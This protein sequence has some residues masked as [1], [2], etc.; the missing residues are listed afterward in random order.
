MLGPG[1]IVIKESDKGHD[2]PEEYIILK[3]YYDGEYDKYDLLC[4]QTGKQ[5]TGENAESYIKFIEEPQ[6]KTKTTTTK[7][8]SRRKPIPG[9]HKKSLSQ[10]A[11]EMSERI[12]DHLGPTEDVLYYSKSHKRYY[13][14]LLTK[15]LDSSSLILTIRGD[16]PGQSQRDITSETL[17][18]YLDKI[19]KQ[20]GSPHGLYIEGG[21]GGGSGGG[22]GGGSKQRRPAAEEADAA[23]RASADTRASA[24][25]REGAVARTESAEQRQARFSGQSTASG[26]S[27][28]RFSSPP[29]GGGGASRFLSPSGGGGGA[30][31]FLSPTGGGGGASR[32]SSPPRGGGGASR[33]SSPPRGGGA[34]PSLT[35]EPDLP[36]GW[37]E[38]TSRTTGH[39]YYYNAKTGKST[40][41]PPPSTTDAQTRVSTPTRRPRLLDPPRSP[42]QVQEAYDELESYEL[43][44]GKKIVERP[45]SVP[46]STTLG[47]FTHRPRQVPPVPDTD[48]D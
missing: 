2:N 14:A 26:K 22:G 48:S 24:A 44:P 4:V 41:D 20:D 25:T 39:R 5:L 42:E 38:H 30:S 27:A 10:Q 3:N 31:R 46:G 6:R 34:P 15:K 45:P 35:G 13:K 9:G 12:E 36:E 43:K 47:S 17:G 18:F 1:Y 29:R 40:Y 19:F 28:S 7:S 33:L 8:K 11:K 32:F 16:Y 23:A 21:G 37:T